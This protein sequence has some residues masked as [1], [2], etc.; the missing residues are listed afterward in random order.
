M[1]KAGPKAT[2]FKLSFGSKVCILVHMKMGL[3]FGKL[4]TEQ[5]N[6]RTKNIDRLSLDKILGLINRE[7]AGV[8]RAVGRV[9]LAVAKASRLIV[10]SLSSGGR[11]FLVGAGTSGR[12][13]V[14]E[15][16]ECPPT[17]NTSPLLV[18]AIMSGGKKAVFRSQEGAEDDERA[19]RAAV[20]RQIRAGD[21]VVGIAASGVTPFVRAALLESKARRARTVLVACNLR[22]SIKADVVI[23]PKTGPEV[24]TGSTRLKAGTATKLILNM[25]TVSAM[26]Q[27]G[28]VYGNWMVDLQPKSKKLVARALRLIQ[29][30]G[31]VSES[32]A[33]K[34]FRQT[35]G[36]SKPA[37][38]MARKRLSY[39]E[40][41]KRLRKTGGFLRK[42]LES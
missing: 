3:D 40:A 29:R 6:P 30:L 38:L 36:R 12:L 26:I 19:A 24:I 13:A 31:G 15:A 18:Q 17:F 10:A 5:Q 41:Q 4:P 33:Q 28:K 8:A 34:L 16:A 22:S 2:R 39:P 7:D 14:L 11:L 27:L 1:F 37:I 42:A 25:L 20:R 32:E 9:K 35:G 21:V 23:A